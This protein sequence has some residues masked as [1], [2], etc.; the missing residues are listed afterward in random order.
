M[1]FVIVCLSGGAASRGGDWI[2]TRGAANLADLIW[3]PPGLVYE[4]WKRRSA[5]NPR[6]EAPKR[7]ARVVS[8]QKGRQE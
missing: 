7:L 8:T 6:R 1:N 3:Q 5:Y 2:M 4:E